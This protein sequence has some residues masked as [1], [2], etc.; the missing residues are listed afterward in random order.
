MLLSIEGR[1]AGIH[2]GITSGLA[3]AAAFSLLVA[4]LFLAV[5]LALLIAWVCGAVGGV[6]VLVMLGAGIAHLLIAGI[7]VIVIKRRLHKKLFVATREQLRK[8]LA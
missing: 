3:A 1:E 7:L 6:W 8:D 2:A 5:T 4:Y